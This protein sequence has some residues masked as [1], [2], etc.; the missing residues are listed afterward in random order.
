MRVFIVGNINAGKSYF[1]EK[2]KTVLTNYKYLSID[3]YRINYGDGSVEKEIECR[4][5]FAEDILEFNDSIIEFSGGETITSLFINRL[6]K[7]SFIIFEVK[8]DVKVCL[9]RLTEKDF[10]KIPYPKYEEKIEDTILRL[11]EEFKNDV[12]KIN[13]NNSYLARYEVSSG[14]DISKLPLKQ[15]ENTIRIADKFDGLCKCLIAYGSLG[16]NELEAYSDVDLFM[17]SDIDFQDILSEIR[18]LF[19]N[20]EIIVQRNQIDIFD[21][22]Q[23]IELTV[24]NSIEEILLYYVKSEIKDISKTILISKGDCEEKL[25]SMVTNYKYDFLSEF[26]YTLSRLQYYSNSLKRIIKKNDLYKYY[27]HSNIVIHEYIKLKYYMLNK[28]EF[29]Y[30]PKYAFNFINIEEFTILTFSVEKEMSE[31]QN[32]VA[33]LVDKISIEAKKYRE[34]LV[35]V[36]NES[37]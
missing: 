33:K 23:L 1:A 18:C 28:R 24:V 15:Y 14:Y 20:S 29:S 25:T 35:G 37:L 2:L 10:A 36:T 16:R 8:E 5:L 34:S 30:L 11:D 27:F 21:D 12:L 9:S 32:K 13:F 17:V 31:H 7:N 26:D 19:N 22:D 3:S 4:K 6:R